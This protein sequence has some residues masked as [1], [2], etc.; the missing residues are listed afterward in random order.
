[1]D[2]MAMPR[3]WHTMRSLANDPIHV[4]IYLSTDAQLCKA[5]PKGKVSTYGALAVILGSCARAT[6]QVKANIHIVGGRIKI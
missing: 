6:G 2:L 4:P 1:M 3:D 5:I